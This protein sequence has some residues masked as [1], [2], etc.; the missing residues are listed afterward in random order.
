MKRK[1][2]A[3]LFTLTMCF[4]LAACGGKEE[5][6]PAPAPTETP[7]ATETAETA[8]IAKEDLLVGF[9]QLSDPSDMGYTYNH[10]LGTQKMKAELGLTD[11]QVISKYNT[12][13]DMNA[14]TAVEELI[15]AG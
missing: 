8:G 6:A 13:D 14:L 7:A 11:E 12:P 10:D 15:E 1:M 2:M 4:T 3:L 5:P 9:V